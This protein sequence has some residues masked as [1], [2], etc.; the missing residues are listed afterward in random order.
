MNRR[1]A[2]FV[3][4][5]AFGLQALM[6]V[7]SAFA[8]PVQDLTIVSIGDSYASGEG[9]PNSF[10][11]TTAT[12]TSTACHKSVNNGRRIAS[13]RINAL[14]N[15]STDF[16]DFSCSGAGVNSGVLNSQ[17]S[18]A[19]E[20]PNAV[21]QAQLDRVALFQQQTGR[22]I[23]ILL[24][25]ISGND[26]NF[27]SVV[28]DCMLPG[29]CATSATVLGA[30][31]RITTVVPGRLDNL[32][33]QIAARLQNIRFVYLTEYPNPMRAENGQSCDG[34]TDFFTA[35][36]NLNGIAMT[37]IS[38]T[39]SQ[40][41]QNNFLIPLNNQL[42]AAA[43]RHSARG[44]RYVSGVEQTFSR[45]GFCNG[46][47]QRWINTLGDSFSRQGNHTGTMHPNLA[48]HHAYADAIIRRATVDFSLP[49]ETPRI[50][51]FVEV[52]DPFV[53]KR[54]RVEISQTAAN[55]AVQAQFRVR[56]P[57]EIGGVPAFTPVN[58]ADIGG[59]ALNFF[60]AALPGTGV[61][62]PGQ[63]IEYRIRVTFSRNGVT[64]SFTTGSRFIE[65]G[66]ASN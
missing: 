12:W 9:N 27:G 66:E 65:F 46:P 1:H 23:D 34:F 11:G 5:N 18:A 40:F 45:H 6:L 24:V 57:I 30:I 13:D 63:R 2:S 33:N 56:N 64:D 22:S 8:Q 48:G 36:D 25:S 47:N 60:D 52:N 20:T 41:L 7:P 14:P 26:A 53:N 58:M 15:T 43:G 16:F 42:E 39:E 3:L 50:L 62:L 35:P 4:A 37:G 32:A 59:G 55:L 19:P 61:M 38:G 21:L 51:D 17:L 54:V 10:N 49:L 44:W 28:L 31:Q 29:N